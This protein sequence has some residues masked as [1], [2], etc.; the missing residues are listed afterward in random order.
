MGKNINRQF[1]EEKMQFVNKNV[2]LS[3]VSRAVEI[4]LSK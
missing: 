3:F 4:T 1:M 2:S